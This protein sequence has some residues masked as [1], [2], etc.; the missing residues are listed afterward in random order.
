MLAATRFNALLKSLE[1]STPERAAGLAA[2]QTVRLHL[3]RRYHGTDSLAGTRLI[4]AWDKGTEIRPPRDIDVL[5]VLRKEP[6]I[7]GA[8]GENASLGILHDLKEALTT[9]RPEAH[10]R[11]DGR[12]VVVPFADAS[13]EVSAGYEQRHGCYEVADGGDG[14]RVRLLA[15]D[16]ERAALDESD[17]RTR[18]CTRA[19]IRL[20]KA[21]QRHRGV[22]ISSFA[23]EL[24][25]VDFMAGWEHAEEGA[26]YYDWMVRD[27]FAHLAARPSHA[28]DVPGT[29][30]SLAIGKGWVS[31]ARLAHEHAAKACEW[32]AAGRDRDAWWEW[33]KI[34][35]DAV[36][37]DERSPA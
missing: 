29:G 36:P 16:A 33:E 18:G 32:E 15:P 23:V 5:L 19:L 31:L 22:P 1:L 13:V 35:G 6:S 26:T 4:G 10:L 34:F 7:P 21:W 11:R 30:E 28:F 24:V 12:A 9:L 27:A 14:G 8:P 25:G 3:A 17:Q 37:F 20:V 2:T